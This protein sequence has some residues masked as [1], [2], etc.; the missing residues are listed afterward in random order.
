MTTTPTLSV[1]ARTMATDGAVILAVE[2][3]LDSHTYSTLESKIDRLINHGESRII[4]DLSGVEF[5]SSAGVR[6]FLTARLKA[7]NE[8][9][10]VVLVSP[11]TQATLVIDTLRMRENLCIANDMADAMK[12]VAAAILWAR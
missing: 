6:V 8:N 12:M 11:S 2:G 5:L 9:G 10:C 7:R 1:T 3:T 4:I